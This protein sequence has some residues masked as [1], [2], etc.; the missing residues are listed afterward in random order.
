MRHPTP[1]HQ[2]FR[3]VVS[4]DGERG[5]ELGEGLV[6][7]RTDRRRRTK[8]VL[9]RSGWAWPLIVCVLSCVPGRVVCTCPGGRSVRGG[10]CSVHVASTF[11]GSQVPLGTARLPPVQ[12]STCSAK[13]MRRGNGIFLLVGAH[14]QPRIA[15]QK[16]LLLKTRFAW[17]SCWIWQASA[18]R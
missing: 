11:A 9:G 8:S 5:E 2:G 16:R 17:N 13:S 4:G 10:G 14:A 15:P 6:I 7:V 1:N 12:I 3:R 18:C